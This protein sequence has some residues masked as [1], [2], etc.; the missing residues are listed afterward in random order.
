MGL[1]PKLKPFAAEKHIRRFNWLL[2]RVVKDLRSV[3]PVQWDV[4]VLRIQETS[5]WSRCSKD[6][7]SELSA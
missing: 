4:E 5:I 2:K 1:H 6:W 3:K 7:F